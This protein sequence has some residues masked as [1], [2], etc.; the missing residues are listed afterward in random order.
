MPDT[1]SSFSA[2]TRRSSKLAV[3]PDR[4]RRFIDAPSTSNPTRL[5][6]AAESKASTRFVSWNGELC[7]SRAFESRLAAPDNVVLSTDRRAERLLGTDHV[8]P[9][10][11]MMSK[12]VPIRDAPNV[13]GAPDQL[14]LTAPAVEWMFLHEAGLLTPAQRRE[15][16][17]FE[18]KYHHAR[19]AMEQAERDERRL[20]Q[21]VH[22]RHSTND[23][24]N[25]GTDSPS[26]AGRH[27]PRGEPFKPDMLSHPSK[28]A[29]L[30]LPREYQKKADYATPKL[31]THDRIFTDTP[32]PWRV[33][34]AQHLRNEGNAGRP[35]DIVNG[36]VV[37]YF[38]PTINEKQH[39]RQ[40]HPSVIVHPYT[41]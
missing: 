21:I 37:S 22:A 3:N 35:F 32:L 14:V 5:V 12:H 15:R 17:E 30:Q 33:E 2:A 6:H 23:V 24:L 9:S 18:T 11:L 25:T 8:P 36:G 1:A 10:G 29:N 31:N 39:P 27:E 7:D 13:G 20:H 38:P 40:G 28:Q 26:A 19:R 16:L 34:R 41:R 4:L